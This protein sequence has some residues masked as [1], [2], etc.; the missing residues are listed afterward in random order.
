MKL[1]AFSHEYL[2]VNEPLPFGVFDA[3]GRLLLNTA[4]AITG[5]E[6]LRQLKAQPVFCDEAESTE[7]RRK[8]HATV[9]GLLRQNATMQAIASARPE[10]RTGA[11]EEARR[12][13]SLPQA[14]SELATVLDASLR[15]PRPDSNWVSRVFAVQDRARRLL[16]RRTDG[17]LY[18]L[19]FHAGHNTEKYSA[20][21]ALLTLL[22]AELAAQRLGLPQDDIDTLGRAA[23]T[24]NVGMT[25]LQDQLASSDLVP[26]PRMREEIRAHAAL[27]ERLLQEGGVVNALWLHAVRHH[28]DSAVPA[29]DGVPQAAAVVGLLRRVDI[30]TAKLSRRRARQPM[31]P[32]QAAR[33]ACLDARGQP[34]A[35]GAALLKAVGLY[36][37]GSYVELG[38]GELGI[39]LARGRQANQAW[40][41]TLVN[42]AGSPVLEPALRDTAEAR[43]AVKQAVAAERVKVRPPHDKLLALRS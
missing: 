15:D 27:G 8:L 39:V 43:F 40:V 20:H 4:Q 29:L 34:D 1:I 18:H 26:S 3:G 5:E 16:T 11:A 28:H 42:A 7:W 32:V 22:V 21:H 2:R 24:M 19:V 6:Q 36:P 13:A 12:E 33:E 14:W 31:S 38:S 30:F 23:L 25:R 37:P 41:G 10:V 17:S 9:D 35:L